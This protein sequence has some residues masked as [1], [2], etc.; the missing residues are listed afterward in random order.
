MVVHVAFY[1][2]GCDE[3]RDAG[4]WRGVGPGGGGF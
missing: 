3:R 1:V 4:L 2:F